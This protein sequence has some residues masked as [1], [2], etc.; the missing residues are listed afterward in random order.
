MPFI[1]RTLKYFPGVQFGRVMRTDRFP[2]AIRRTPADSR[3]HGIDDRGL[4]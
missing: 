2:D 1:D 4:E 3:A